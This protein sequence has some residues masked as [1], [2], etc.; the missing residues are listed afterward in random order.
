MELQLHGH[1]FLTEYQVERERLYTHI[2]E[3]LPVISMYMH[4]LVR[5]PC[6]V[7][8]LVTAALHVQSL[9]QS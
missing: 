3:F 9:V 8:L 5:C 7:G 4:T 6:P 1:E 2:R